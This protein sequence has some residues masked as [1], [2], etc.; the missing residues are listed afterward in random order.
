MSRP[1]V[2]VFGATGFLGG[3]VVSR[4]VEAGMTVRVAAR[5]PERLAVGQ[6]SADIVPVAA[7]VRSGE[8]V[9]T[10]IEGAQAVVNAVGL[11]VERGAETFEAVHVHGAAAVAKLAARAGVKKLIHVSGIGAHPSSASR[12]VRARARGERVVLDRFP[13]AT[14]VRPSV[15]FGAGDAFLNTI[16]AITRAAPV[17]PLFGDGRTRLQPVFVGDVAEGIFRLIDGDEHAGL[18]CEFGGPGVHTYREVVEMVLRFRRRRRL[19]LPV[20]FALWWTQAKLL[21]LLPAPPLTEDQVIL[22]R[23]DNL[24]SEGAVTLQALGASS[25][26]LEAM[27]PQCLGSPTP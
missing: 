8:N 7:D 27:L 25:H 2:T 9:T 13:A 17:F 1:T 15:L 16:D 24:V 23:D 4:L 3:A 11:Y 6:S 14:I 19:L 18:V 21:S 22:M 12:Y 20:P 26:D 5:R 10:A